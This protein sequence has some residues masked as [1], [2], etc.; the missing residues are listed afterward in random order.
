MGRGLSGHGKLDNSQ[1][2]S[3]IRKL[4]PYKIVKK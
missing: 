4:L 1:Y 2:M 3:F